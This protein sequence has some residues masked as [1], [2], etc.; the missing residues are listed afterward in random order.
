MSAYSALLVPAPKHTPVAVMPVT[1]APTAGVCAALLEQASCVVADPIV[2]TK[3]ATS[4]VPLT[5]AVIV[6]LPGTVPS[7]TCVLAVPLVSVVALAGF[8]VAAPAV[9]ANV[10]PTFRTGDPLDITFT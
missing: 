2:S 6:T 5:V 8:S 1:T 3:L 9:T 10:T 4:D 7:V